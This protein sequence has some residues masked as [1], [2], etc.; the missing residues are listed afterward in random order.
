MKHAKVRSWQWILLLLVIVLGVLMYQRANPPERPL[1]DTEKKAEVTAV[2]EVMK[3]KLSSLPRECFV[4]KMNG[5]LFKDPLY[6]EDDNYSVNVY[7]KYGVT[8]AT[9][10]TIK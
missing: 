2:D 1:T 8:A 3:A 10:L 7:V 4:A 6:P 5:G 9:I